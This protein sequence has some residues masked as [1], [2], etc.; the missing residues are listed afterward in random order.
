[1]SLH[2]KA[3][4]FL[5]ASN[6]ALATKASDLDIPVRHERS[7][8]TAV[9]PYIFPVNTI[10][11]MQNRTRTNLGYFQVIGVFNFGAEGDKFGL[12]STMTSELVYLGHWEVS[13]ME[14]QGRLRPLENGVEKKQAKDP[15]KTVI[16]DG[17]ELAAAERRHE[18][19]SALAKAERGGTVKL[20]RKLK[21]EVAR[22]VAESR[23]EDAPPC[24]NTLTGWLETYKKSS[25]NR[26]VALATR[27]SSG[28]TTKKFCERLELVVEKLVEDTWRMPGG[29]GTDLEMALDVEL[30]RVENSEFL[31][32]LAED[33]GTVVLPSVRTLQRR[34]YAVNKYVRDCWRYG[35]EA[36]ARIH[37]FF[38]ARDLPDHILGVVEVDYTTADMSV[39]DDELPILY[40]RPFVLFIIERKTGS[41]L[42]FDLH[43]DNPS[44]E[45]F[46]SAVRRGMYPKDMSEFPGQT[47]IQYGP[48]MVMTVDNAKFFVGD[49]MRHACACL[50][51]D[52]LENHPGEPHGKGSVEQ[53]FRRLNERLFHRLPGTT[54]SNTLRK[55]E[56]D[57]SKGLGVPVLTLSQLRRFIQLFIIEYHNTPRLGIGKN[58]KIKKTPNEAWIECSG[59]FK[60]RRPIDPHLFVSLAGNT[61]DF[62]VQANGITWDHITYCSP[63][64]LM[65]STHPSN[66][67][68]KPGAL[69]TRYRCSRNPADLGRI[70]VYDP[71]RKV[72]IE[73]P[74]VGPS[75]KY[76]EGLRL[77]QH[78]AVVKFYNRTNK[79][80][81][82]TIDDL[83]N[84]RHTLERALRDQMAD[85]KKLGKLPSARLSAFF[86]QITKKFKKTAIVE[87]PDS[88]ADSPDMMDLDAPFKSAPLGAM[89]AY[90]PD[91]R[92]DTAEVYAADEPVHGL[93]QS[94]PQAGAD[95]AH[96]RRGRGRP[97]KEKSGP[98]SKPQ[99]PAARQA[100][101][102]IFADEDALHEEL[103]KMGY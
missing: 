9:Q 61:D 47:W 6:L 48:W 43:F 80:P 84:A 81:I 58:P 2:S 97:P 39:W 100:V 40:G 82:R 73:V 15:I 93:A 13:L 21:L 65:L 85:Q 67:R 71:Y 52:L 96:K 45:A 88:V 29:R 83:V 101:A 92:G 74:A 91:S 4:A 64:L 49:D 42:S 102:D 5:D 103:R 56:F 10:L 22:Q 77:F 72:S 26:V 98:L 25:Y 89:A 50:G 24:Y 44:F 95:E 57:E 30:G 70:W 90:D 51:F 75:R 60:H 69:S 87:V 1:M 12:R 94:D 27:K 66:N 8:R 46:L 78:R 16:L 11:A 18:Y 3:T 7:N 53:M 76:A 34:F 86:S 38:V 23:K 63:E 14:Q 32:A 54:M 31:K 20:G 37:S 17:D 28:N 41:I 59:D 35:E 33:D 36:A 79:R 19:C 68:A 62:T 55:A 99:Q